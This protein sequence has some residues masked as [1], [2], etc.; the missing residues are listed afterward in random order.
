[1]KLISRFYFRD[2]LTCLFRGKEKERE[3]ERERERERERECV[4][5]CLPMRLFITL[6]SQLDPIPWYLW[7]HHIE[8][9]PSAV[10]SPF[11]SFFTFP[12]VEPSYKYDNTRGASSSHEITP[13]DPAPLLYRRHYPS[14]PVLP[15]I[16]R[17]LSLSTVMYYSSSSFVALRYWKSEN[18]N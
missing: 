9:V 13:S 4:C 12:R 2:I 8:R 6:F 10:P 5:V 18:A 1:M 11:P 3:K 17:K 16:E 15:S 7:A 14:L